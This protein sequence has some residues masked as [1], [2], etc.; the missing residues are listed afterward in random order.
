MLNILVTKCTMSHE[1]K[2]YFKGCLLDTFIVYLYFYRHG[3]HPSQTVY[4]TRTNAKRI[5]Y[6]KNIAYLRI[7]NERYSDAE[8]SL[9]TTRERARLCVALG[10]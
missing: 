1:Q 8:L 7:S 5:I 2:F 3:P 10:D 9:L 4:D 6:Y